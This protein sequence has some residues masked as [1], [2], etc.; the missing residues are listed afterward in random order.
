MKAL[1]QTALLLAFGVCAFAQQWEVGGIGGGSFLDSISVKTPTAGSATAGFAPGPVAGAFFGQRMNDALERRNPL[2]VLRYQPEAQERRHSTASFNGVAHAVHYDLLYHTN[3]KGSPL[4]LFVAAG[5]GMKVFVGTGLQEAIQPLSQFGYFTQTHE[6]KAMASAGGGFTYKI[7][8]HLS[9]RA[10]IRD[11]IS[12]FPTKVIAPPAGAKYG[13][14]LQDIVPMVG[15]SYLFCAAAPGGRIAC[16]K[17]SPVPADSSGMKIALA[18]LL[19]ISIL[20]GAWSMS[21]STYLVREVPHRRNVAR[22][23]T[24]PLAPSRAQP[25]R[26]SP[27]HGQSAIGA[28]SRRP[29]VRWGPPAPVR[30]HPRTGTTVRICR[31][32]R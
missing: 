25:A 17:H 1:G 3:R 19:L 30:A 14:V 24:A 13:K 15:L 16:L 10:E 28:G 5:G 22:S 27:P 7:G 23:R 20:P 21:N 18:V 6:V 12:A 29:S 31:G 8:E 32:C 2:R 4:Q 11:L 26:A 9:F